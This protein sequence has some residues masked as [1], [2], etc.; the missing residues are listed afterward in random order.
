MRIVER[1][2]ACRETT[3]ADA[4]V[5]LAQHLG[6]AVRRVEGGWLQMNAVEV[7]TPDERTLSFKKGAG[8]VG[9]AKANLC[10]D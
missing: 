7:T 10:S 4:A 8:F 3:S 9:W 6:Y 2:V 5:D 1:G